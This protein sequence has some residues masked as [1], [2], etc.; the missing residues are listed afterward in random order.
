MTLSPSASSDAHI[1]WR[2]PASPPTSRRSFHHAEGTPTQ[3]RATN[4]VLR[5]VDERA[6][7]FITALNGPPQTNEVG[8]AAGLVLGLLLGIASIRASTPATRDGVA[9]AG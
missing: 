1:G 3:A 5:L 8:R 2:S 4:E 6:A 7:D 9:P